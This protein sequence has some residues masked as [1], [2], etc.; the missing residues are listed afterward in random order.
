MEE[1][2]LDLRRVLRQVLWPRRLFLRLPQ[3]WVF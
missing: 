2:Y 1:W 3:D